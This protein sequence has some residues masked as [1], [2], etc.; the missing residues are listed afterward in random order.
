[1]SSTI[2][3]ARTQ[4]VLSIAELCER[5]RRSHTPACNGF[6]A[7]VEDYASKRLPAIEQIVEANDTVAFVHETNG[8]IDGL[9]LGRLLNAPPVYDPG[10]K[11]CLIGDFFVE[12]PATWTD[13]GEALVAAADARVQEFG[14]VLACIEC[15]RSDVEKREL[16]LSLKFS[17]ASDW[18]CRDC[19]LSATDSK[20]DGE[21]EPASLDDV[22]AIIALC[23]QR[24]LQ[25]QQYQP[26]FWRK[27]TDSAEKQTPYIAKLIEEQ[28][29]IILVHRTYN[30]VDGFII[31]DPNASSALYDRGG[32][33]CGVDDFRVGNDLYQSVGARLLY[34]AVT[35]AKS[36]GA[37]YTQVVCGDADLSKR[38]MLEGMGFNLGHEWFVRDIAKG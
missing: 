26:T 30:K 3:L 34:E 11:V 6:Y 1:M 32:P 12:K 9:I 8:A 18:Y 13:A 29:Q 28:K 24:R 35:E 38:T 36:R 31:A 20:I 4:D 10:G 15:M 19:N 33:S 14:G 22:P 16:L 25:Y 37:V 23:E 27:A 5:E 2:R 21:I 7:V 17:V